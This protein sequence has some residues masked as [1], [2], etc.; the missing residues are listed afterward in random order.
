MGRS[1]RL[2]LPYPPVSGNH[3]TKHTRNGRHYTTDSARDYAS[4]V[5]EF[6]HRAG[7]AGLK[8]KGPLDVRY[9]AHAPD[10][11]DR[12]SCNV[13]KIAKDAITKAEVWVDDSNKVIQREEF[14][15]FYPVPEGMLVVEIV[16]LR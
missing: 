4:R 6:A 10:K 15:W 13:M 8:L 9:D 1:F 2:I 11:L 7:V 5:A 12:D 16:E 14:R 3:A